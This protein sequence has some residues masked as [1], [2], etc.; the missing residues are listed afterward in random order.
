MRR[1]AAILVLACVLGGCEDPPEWW[2]QRFG[3]PEPPAPLPTAPPATTQPA[4]AD[5]ANAATP[6]PRETPTPAPTAQ[7][8]TVMAYVNGKP[9]YMAGFVDLLVRGYGMGLAQQFI[10]NELVRQE[11]A[12]QKVTITDEDV[13]AQHERTLRD[14][15]GGV[16]DPNQQDRLLEQLLDR[17]KVSRQQWGLTMRRNALLAK[18]AGKR[19]VTTEAD[20]KQEFARQHEQKVEIQH[21]QVATLAD[22]QRVLRELAG[23]AEFTALVNKDSVGPSVKNGGLLPAFGA[24]DTGTPPAIREAA[25][26]MTKIG[27]VSDPIQV[28]TAFHVV[29]LLRIIEPKDVKFEDVR[30]QMRQAVRAR[31]VQALQQDILQILIAGARVEYVNAVL[32][33]QADTGN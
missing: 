19:V 15:F 4:G 30:E 13:R 27:E 2:T 10:A 24:R 29:K 21:I 33:A 3:Q 23:G 9:V 17:N 20:L 6:A 1:G 5:D 11:A 28:G 22:A 8:G 16:E 18:L 7:G 12:R 25:L 32:K 14:M 31:K 26:A